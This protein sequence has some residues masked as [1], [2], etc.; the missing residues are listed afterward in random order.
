MILYFWFGYLNFYKIMDLHLR[1]KAYE[2]YKDE[3]GMSPL[4]NGLSVIIY[5]NE[6]GGFY[7]S[8]SEK[9]IETFAK[10]RVSNHKVILIYLLSLL[11][12]GICLITFASIMLYKDPEL[13]VLLT[14]IWA[15][16]GLGSSVVMLVVLWI[17]KDRQTVFIPFSAPDNWPDD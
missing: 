3:Y 17:K 7:Y 14:K 16:G 11:I 1:G 9:K 6:A 4:E 5:D 8:T 15:F 12:T 13:C 2:L 10:S